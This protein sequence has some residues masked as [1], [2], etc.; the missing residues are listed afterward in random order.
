MTTL[1]PGSE[2]SVL[3]CDAPFSTLDR[4]VREHLDGDARVHVQDERTSWDM[5][6]NEHASVSV[7]AP[8]IDRLRALR[9]YLSN[10]AA[11]RGEGPLPG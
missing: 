11:L 8:R 9:R 10:L 5:A 4:D 1:E 2:H 6:A 3:V 7:V